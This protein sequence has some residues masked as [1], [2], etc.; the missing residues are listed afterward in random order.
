M[1]MSTY[2]NPRGSTPTAAIPVERP[3]LAVKT[4]APTRLAVTRPVGLIVGAEPEEGAPLHE[5]ADVQ[6]T[7]RR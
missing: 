7:T 4:P 1:V 6:S 3:T 2:Q 5:G